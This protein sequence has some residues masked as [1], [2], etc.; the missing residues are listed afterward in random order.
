MACTIDTRG[1]HDAAPT[2]RNR[3]TVLRLLLTNLWLRLQCVYLNLRLRRSGIDPDSIPETQ[4]SRRQRAVQSD[5]NNGPSNG[6]D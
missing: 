3:E 1:P 5:N 6:H 4:E 2:A